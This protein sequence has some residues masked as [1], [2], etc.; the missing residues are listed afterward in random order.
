MPANPQIRTAADQ[1]VRERTRLEVIGSGVKS[2]TNDSERNGDRDNYAR[3][4][5]NASAGAQVIRQTALQPRR[6]HSAALARP[7]APAYIRPS[8]A[9]RLSRLP[10]RRNRE[11]DGTGPQA[12]RCHRWTLRSRAR[13]RAWRYG[14]R[15][16]GT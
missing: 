6:T 2:R 11:R 7:P 12:K 15:I 1:T 10:T 3:L 16:S 9:P 14:N 4:P 13:A 5:R 8:P